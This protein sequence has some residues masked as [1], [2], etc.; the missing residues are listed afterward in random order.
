MLHRQVGCLGQLFGQT[1]KFNGR[2]IRKIAIRLDRL[3]DR[4][5]RDLPPSITHFPPVGAREGEIDFIQPPGLSQR[6]DEFRGACIVR[7]LPTRPLHEQ[8]IGD[9][10]RTVNPGGKLIVKPDDLR[11]CSLKTNLAHNQFF[12]RCEMYY[13]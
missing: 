12:S 2:V 7:Q 10:S 6:F 9:V 13:I 3:H 11:Q 5:K 4:V 1:V 8:M